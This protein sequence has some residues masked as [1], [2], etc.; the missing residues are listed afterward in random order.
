MDHDGVWKK[1]ED[2]NMRE[3]GTRWRMDQDGGWKKIDDRTGWSMEQ[4]RG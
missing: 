4:Y 3:D 1:L 2:R